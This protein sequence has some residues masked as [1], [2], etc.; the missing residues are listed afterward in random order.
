MDIT[1][2]ISLIVGVAVSTGFTQWVKKQ[3]GLASLGAVIL[4]LVIAFGVSISLTLLQHFLA[5]G[6]FTWSI[7]V[8]N[9]TT[10]FTMATIV[11]RAVLSGKTKR[12]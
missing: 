2:I 10:I 7:V 11:Y 1:E 3:T 9:A 12:K 4:T 8:Q 6:E 5:T